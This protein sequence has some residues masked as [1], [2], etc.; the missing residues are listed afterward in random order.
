M[1]P[2]MIINELSAIPW[3]KGCE[4]S[5]PDIGQLELPFPVIP[6]SMAVAVSI[7]STI[8]GALSDRVD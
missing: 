7:A 4:G 5:A 1:Q 2:L 3:I 8:R 6:S